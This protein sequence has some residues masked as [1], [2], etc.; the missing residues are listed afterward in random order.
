MK[1]KNIK[2]GVLML[3]ILTGVMIVLNTT[4]A[5]KVTLTTTMGDIVIELYSNKIL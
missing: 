4:G 2:V 1:K 3:L 5:K